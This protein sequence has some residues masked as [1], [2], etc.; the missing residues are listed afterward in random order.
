MLS[1][2][3]SSVATRSLD[4]GD[5]A[6]LLEQSRAANGR[7]GV[8]G[9]LFFRNGYFLQLLEGPDA[10]VRAKLE[11]IKRDDRHT[12]VR[13]ISEELLEERQFPE[14][15]MGFPATERSLQDVPGYRTTF[16][17]LDAAADLGPSASAVRELT[18]WF[19]PSG[20]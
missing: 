10:V 7:E 9:V 4:E 6:A 11:R 3:Y 1:L 13:L 19:R 14:W 12:K 20:G 18:R 8:T 15:T 2:I 16:D 5:L 17:D